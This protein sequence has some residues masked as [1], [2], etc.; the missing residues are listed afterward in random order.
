[1]DDETPVGELLFKLTMHKYIVDKRAT[2][3]RLR[4]NIIDL[5]T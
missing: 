2:N 5:D 4:E 1:M 3:T